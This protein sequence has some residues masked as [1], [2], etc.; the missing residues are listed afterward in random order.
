[1]LPNQSMKNDMKRELKTQT[2][3]REKYNT[4]ITRETKLNSLIGY[5]DLEEYKRKGTGD[6]SGNEKI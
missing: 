3:N 2:K 4:C 5:L 1:M 6:N